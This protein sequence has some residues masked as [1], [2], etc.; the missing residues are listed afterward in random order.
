MAQVPSIQVQVFSCK[1]KYKYIG[2]PLAM[3]NENKQDSWNKQK[4]LWLLIKDNDSLF[5]K[6]FSTC[7]FPYRHV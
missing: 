7:K 5:Q 4:Y 3:Q 6:H 1:Y 2:L